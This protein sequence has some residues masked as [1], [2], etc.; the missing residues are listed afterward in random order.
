M[1]GGITVALGDA[2]IIKEMGSLAGSGIGTVRRVTLEMGKD[3]I[4]ADGSSGVFATCWA[5]VTQRVARAKFTRGSCA[6]SAG[7][8]IANACT[9][10]IPA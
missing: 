2:S 10:P 4:G 8:A 5:L 7:S 9:V 3:V 1:L 6:N